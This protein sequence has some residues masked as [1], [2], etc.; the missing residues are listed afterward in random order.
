M[1]N[2][3][4]CFENE[5]HGGE[6]FPTSIIH[7]HQ[8]PH[9]TTTTTTPAFSIFSLRKQWLVSGVCLNGVCMYAGA[10]DRLRCQIAC[11]E[12][13]F[14]FVFVF[15]RSFLLELLFN[16]S[17]SFVFSLMAFLVKHACRLSAS[18]SFAV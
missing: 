15:S 10:V 14:S 1:K 5:H 11:Y 13:V 9:H 8:P 7:H 18:I 4:S 17:L 12:C 3:S 16:E 2:R 6:T